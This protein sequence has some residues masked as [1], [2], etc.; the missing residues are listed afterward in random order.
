MPGVAIGD[1]LL[2][3]GQLGQ[4][5]KLGDCP[6]GDVYGAWHVPNGV[7][8]GR[9]HAQDD[10]VVGVIPVTQV[11]PH[12]IGAHNRCL[13]CRK[14]AICRSPNDLK[15]TL[16]AEV[17]LWVSIG[18]HSLDRRLLDPI[19]PLAGVR[20]KAFR[21]QHLVVR[22]PAH[23]TK[24]E[25]DSVVAQQIED[26]CRDLARVTRIAVDHNLLIG[27]QFGQVLRLG[28]LFPWYVH[29][30]RDVPDGE[31]IG[32]THAEDEGIVVW[33]PIVHVLPQGISTDHRR[34]P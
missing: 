14:P 23:H 17:Q 20:P 33:V 27:R 18:L 5:L 10:R 4:I 19:V 29:G 22:R 9:A 32:R 12:R 13:G 26:R 2:V 34:F 25:V 8:V 15:V 11:F 7:M 16:Y 28:D 6:P 30:T 31:V 3:W 1:N 21:G 24:L